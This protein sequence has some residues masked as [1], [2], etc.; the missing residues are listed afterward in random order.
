MERNE[1]FEQTPLGQPR[2]IPG[3]QIH[4]SRQISVTSIPVQ[5]R[6][7]RHQLAVNG[8]RESKLVA[9]HAIERRQLPELAP[10]VGT[11]LIA[12]KNISCTAGGAGI[13]ERGACN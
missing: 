4:G 1:F 3:I 2:V 9:V 12:P 8:D 5:V 6:T 13:C 10:L 7:D 11:T